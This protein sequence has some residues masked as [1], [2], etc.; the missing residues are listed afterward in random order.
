MF[1][2]LSISEESFLQQLQEAAGPLFYFSETEMPVRVHRIS[3][4]QGHYRISS[5]DLLRKFF[6]GQKVRK[7]E[8]SNMEVP[9]SKGYQRF[10]RHQLDF[11]SQ[12]GRGNIQIRYPVEREHALLWRRLRDL[13]IDHL[14]RQRWFKVHLSDGVQ[15]RIFA[16][17]Q[18][19]EIR[20]NPT[21]NEVQMFPGAWFVLETGAVET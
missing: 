21:T 3:D 15:K 4:W 5:S 12:D 2:N 19:L 7:V 13:W 6:D 8:W 17:G 11:I 16:A 14:V 9:G 10:F 20:I 1:E 18:F